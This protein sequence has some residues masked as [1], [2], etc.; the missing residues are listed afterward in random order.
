MYSA[1]PIITGGTMGLVLSVLD[2]ALRPRLASGVA[3]LFL[4]FVEG[5][6]CYVI[7]TMMTTE[8]KAA[9]YALDGSLISNSTLAGLTIWLTDFFVKPAM[10]G[11]AGT[12]IIKFLLQGIIVYYV[13]AMATGAEE[14]K[15]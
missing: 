5:A 8:K 10:L 6:S 2:M 3:E 13:L 9:T 7:Y 12:E 4:F 14:I 15:K 1:H 11:G